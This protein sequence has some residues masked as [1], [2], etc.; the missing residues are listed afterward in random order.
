VLF[1]NVVRKVNVDILALL[2]IKEIKVIKE[3]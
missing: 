1:V 2:A 3:K